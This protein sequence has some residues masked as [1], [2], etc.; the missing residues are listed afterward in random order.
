MD[1]KNDTYTTS[2]NV[3]RYLPEGVRLADSSFDGNVAVT[4]NIEKTVEQI[5]NVP[6]ENLKFINLPAGKSAE[7]NLGGADIKEEG[8]KHYLM[9]KGIG[10]SGAFDDIEGNDITGYVNVQAY[11]DELG[12]SEL[13]MATILWEFYLYF[14]MVFRPTMTTRSESLISDKK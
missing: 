4:V 5:I 1:G 6:V 8:G 14:L 13:E 9:F 2:V 7:I 12:V 3:G 11:M 10:V